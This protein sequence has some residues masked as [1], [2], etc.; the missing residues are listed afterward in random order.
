LRGILP[1]DRDPTRGA[2]AVGLAAT[3]DDETAPASNPLRDLRQTLRFLPHGQVFLFDRGHDHVI[4][5]HHFVEMDLPHLRQQF[6]GI[7]F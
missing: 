1:C 5:I 6:V 2:I 4:W 3:K 7:E